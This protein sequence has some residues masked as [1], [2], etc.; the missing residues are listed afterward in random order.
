MSAETQPPAVHHTEIISL[1][2]SRPAYPP[3]I[4]ALSNRY[5]GINRFLAEYG[6]ALENDPD[7][8]FDDCLIFLVL[9]KNCL[10]EGIAACTGLT[11][12]EVDARFMRRYSGKFN[13][14]ENSKPSV[15]MVTDEPEPPVEEDVALPTIMPHV[16]Q[17]APISRL[18]YGLLRKAKQRQPKPQKPKRHPY[19]RRSVT[20]NPDAS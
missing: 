6:K 16:Y 15:E 20:P 5:P 14:N 2:D 9:E 7:G 19:S 4:Q 1:P 3:L 11:V 8:L 13:D 18:T 12:Y 10:L 17:A